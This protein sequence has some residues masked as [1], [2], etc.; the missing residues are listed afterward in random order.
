MWTPTYENSWE[1]FFPGFQHLSTNVEYIEKEDEFDI[2]DEGV[3]VDTIMREPGEPI[4][5]FTPAY[6]EPAILVDLPLN[7]DEL[8]NARIESQKQINQKEKKTDEE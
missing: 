4:D 5:I 1:Q 6:E 2:D 8:V 3:H 7:I